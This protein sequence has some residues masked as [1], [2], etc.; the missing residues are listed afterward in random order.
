MKKLL[1]TLVACFAW[2]FAFADGVVY[3]TNPDGWATPYVWIWNSSTNYTGGN[4]PGK[5]MTKQSDG[6]WKYEWTGTGTPTNVIFSNNGADSQKTGD[7]DYVEGAVYNKLGP[8]N[9]QTYEH[10]MCLVKNVSGWQKVFIYTNS[11]AVGTSGSWP[12]QQLDLLPGSNDTY[13][14]VVTTTSETTPSVGMFIFNNGNSGGDNQTGDLSD[15]QLGATYTTKGVIAGETSY[16]IIGDN[17]NG[18]GSWNFAEKFTDN[19]DG[20]YVWEGTQLGNNFKFTDAPNWQNGNYSSNGSFLELGTPYVPANGGDNIEFENNKMVVNNP[21]VVLTPTSNGITV[22]VTGEAEIVDPATWN[23][24]LAGDFNDWN[25]S[26][27]DYIFTNNGDETW[28]GTFSL[29]ASEKFQ[30]VIGNTW[31]GSTGGDVSVNPATQTSISLNKGMDNNYTLPSDWVSTHKQI[32]FTVSY[33]DMTATLEV[34]DEP[35]PEFLYLRGSL[36]SGNEIQFVNEGDGIFTKE[37]SLAPAEEI[38][39]TLYGNESYYY[40]APEG[41]ELVELQNGG[42]VE[43]N[44]EEGGENPFVIRDFIGGSINFTVSLEDP[45]L[46]LEWTAPSLYL[47]GDDINGAG[48][49][50]TNFPGTFDATAGT[51]TWSV[52]Q[53][54]S[55]FKITDDPI[56]WKGY[57]NIGTGSDNAY[58]TL[59]FGEPFE[60]LNSGDSNNIAFAEPQYYL[61]NVTV[62]LNLN[63]DTLTVNGSPEFNE[64]TGVYVAGSFNG[65]ENA[66]EDEENALTLENGVYSG[67]LNLDMEDPEFKIVVAYGEVNSWYGADQEE[68]TIVFSGVNPVEGLSLIKGENFK[69]DG[70]ISGDVTFTVDTDEMT[71]SVYYDAPTPLVIYLLGDNVDGESVWENPVEMTLEEDGTWT[72]SGSELGSKFKFSNGSWTEGYNFGAEDADNELELGVAFELVNSEDSKNI[73]L[74]ENTYIENPSVVLDID[75]LTVTVTGTVISTAPYEPGEVIYLMTSLDWEKGY[76]LTLNEEGLYTASIALAATEDESPLEFKLKCDDQ[77]WYGAAEGEEEV[78]LIEGKETTLAL[79]ANGGNWSLA[80]YYDGMVVD[81][82]VD[83]SED[84]LTLTIGEGESDGIRSIGAVFSETDAIYTLQGVR[85]DAN[86]LSKGIYIINGKKVMVR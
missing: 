59:F 8:V 62:T 6:N 28:T 52:D 69:L 14:W 82:T 23:C 61:S 27:P 22:L 51:Y 81:V 77:H 13:Q 36:S 74:A 45:I 53:L 85:I 24:Y 47:V 18:L 40:G 54:G 75:K 3:F 76:E 72:W 78:T 73:L 86:K 32:K 35:L 11:P 25:P 50:N 42:E 49:W 60:Y 20:T 44:I 48:N 16:Y 30:F 46:V 41:E 34:V 56:D 10:V 57:Y 80:D 7:L 15:F 83:W 67:T 64:V 71:L 70:P 38:S 2:L 21:K 55:N 68:A 43:I 33:S 65:W 1:L 31:Y 66:L 12:G 19:Q 37:L 84:A 17:I 79:D 39:F 9:A 63:D 26:D 29:E 5:A 58:K 4:W